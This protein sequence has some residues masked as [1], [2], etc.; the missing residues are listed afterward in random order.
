[1]PDGLAALAVWSVKSTP[2]TPLDPGT[3]TVLV[4]LSTLV[5]AVTVTVPAPAPTSAM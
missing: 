2:E 4:L 3:V 5:A 1:L